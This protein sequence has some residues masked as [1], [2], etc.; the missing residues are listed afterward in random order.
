MAA[1]AE[2]HR[3]DRRAVAV[4]VVLA[5]ALIVVSLTAEGA[6]RDDLVAALSYV[7]AFRLV[8]FIYTGRRR[9]ALVVLAVPLVFGAVIGEW[10]AVLLALVNGV[11]GA[12][13]GV[14]RD[15]PKEPLTPRELGIWVGMEA[16]VLA[17]GVVAGQV[18]RA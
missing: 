16:A 10:W 3:V 7:L 1:N 9:N 11:F 6:A 18:G 4:S 5:A 2:R 17:L 13:F 8:M 14:R 12:V 15:V